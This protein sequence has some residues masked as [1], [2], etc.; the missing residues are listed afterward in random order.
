MSPL[1]RRALL[2]GAL[3]TA[4]SLPL[5]DAMSGSAW[6]GAPASPKR[7]VVFYTPNGTVPANFWPTAEGRDFPLSPILEPL[8]KHRDDLLVLGNVDMLSAL[9]GPGDA[10]QKGTG[11]CLTATELQHGDFP[12]DAGAQAGWADH[13]SIDQHIANHIGTDTPLRSLELGVAVQGSDVYSR[14]VY[15]GPGQPLPPENS[16]YTAYQRLFADALVDPA[17]F[18]RRL[19]R[20]QKTIDV[21]YDD[22][23]RLRAKLG[24]DDRDKLEAH[25]LALGALEERLSRRA[26]QF[27]DTCQPLDQGIPIDA[28]SVSN[29]P[30]VGPLQMEL[31]AQAFACDLTRVASIQWSYSTSDHVYRFVDSDI[32][33]GHHLLAHKGD[34]DTRKVL[35][36]TRINAWFASQLAELISLLKSIPE[37][38]GT[39]FDH[40]VILWTNE[41]SKGNNHDRTGIPYVLA[42]SGGGHFDTGR[43]VV[44][45]SP[46]GHQQLMVSLMQAYGIEGDTFGNPE[47]GTGPLAGLTA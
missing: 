31:I 42:G 29:M 7:F 36:N 12:G 23:R 10:H 39:V 45:P 18:E 25:L 14:I 17:V 8:A 34:E 3:G 2:R 46:V 30:V 19:Q 28:S 13:I 1:N 35:Q 27:T 43:H 40:T 33:E 41:Q 24:P 20:R 21:V 37:G 15:A 47:Y 9:S 38:E 11:Q 4:L 16:P 22:F 26:V 5:L 44:Q 6:A 32:R